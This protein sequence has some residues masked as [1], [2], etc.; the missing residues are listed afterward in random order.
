VISQKQI[1][2]EQRGA[3]LLAVEIG[4][5]AGAPLVGSLHRALFALGVNICSYRARLGNEGLVE[6]IVLEHQDGQRIEGALS[7]LTKAAILPIALGA[8]AL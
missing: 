7:A 5:T 1:R 4:Q 6:H 2:F 3:E 8:H